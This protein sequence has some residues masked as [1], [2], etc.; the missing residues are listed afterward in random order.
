MELLLTI[1]FIIGM[2]YY[3]RRGL[4][5]TLLVGLILLH[6]VLLMVLRITWYN[7]SVPDALEKL[8]SPWTLI[9]VTAFII[10]L[11]IKV[12]TDRNI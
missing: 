4:T 3:A 9:A 7:M 6:R 8:L 5:L 2:L 11:I 10:L 12:M 1:L